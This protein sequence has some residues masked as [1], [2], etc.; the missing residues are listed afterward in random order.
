MK[1]STLRLNVFIVLIF[2]AHSIFAQSDSL[3]VKSDSLNNDSINT[4]LLDEYNKALADI[5]QQRLRR[6]HRKSV[7]L[8]AQLNSLKNYG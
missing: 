4:V 7:E 5:E 8:E 6:F 2:I 3:Q 1:I